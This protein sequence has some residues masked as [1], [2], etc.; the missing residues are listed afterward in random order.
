VT[1]RIRRKLQKQR[2]RCEQAYLDFIGKHG[3]CKKDWDDSGRLL[4]HEGGYYLHLMNQ[5]E[6]PPVLKLSKYNQIKK[7]DDDPN[8]FYKDCGHDV[9]LKDGT[10]WYISPESFKTQLEEL[11]KRIRFVGVRYINGRNLIWLAFKIWGLSYLGELCVPYNERSYVVAQHL[12]ESIS[13]EFEALLQNITVQNLMGSDFKSDSWKV[14]EISSQDSHLP[15]YEEAIKKELPKAQNRAMNQVWR[16]INGIKYESTSWRKD[17]NN[18]TIFDMEFRWPEMYGLDLSKK[19]FKLE[20]AGNN[21]RLEDLIPSIM[22][23]LDKF[24]EEHSISSKIKA[25]DVRA[26]AP[27]FIARIEPVFEDQK[28]KAHRREVKNQLRR[29]LEPAVREFSIDEI[30]EWIDEFTVSTVMDE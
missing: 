29:W 24:L 12:Q 22:N 26:K 6:D 15:N 16:W 10:E 7:I 17:W 1:T 20:N 2:A 14:P 8:H 11:Y 25:G 13:D 3:V 28:K 23:L 21:T 4:L 19:T 30:R 27:N 9:V 5:E 18:S